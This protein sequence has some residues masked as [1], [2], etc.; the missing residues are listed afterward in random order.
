MRCLEERHMYILKI[1]SPPNDRERVCDI[2]RDR[3]RVRGLYREGVRERE[4]KNKLSKSKKAIGKKK[5]KRCLHKG[6]YDTQKDSESENEWVL[7]RKRKRKRRRNRNTL[8]PHIGK[9]VIILKSFEKK[10]VLKAKP[11]KKI[12]IKKTIFLPPLSTL[13][14]HRCVQLVNRS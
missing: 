3:D 10:I 9:S 13:P 4:W 6:V 11:T 7:G 1:W 5:I 8:F 2:E 14:H 12:K